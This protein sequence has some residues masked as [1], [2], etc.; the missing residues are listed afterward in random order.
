MEVERSEFGEQWEDIKKKD[1]VNLK[2]QP[3]NVDELLSLLR[4]ISNLGEGEW[5][6]IREDEELLGAK[7]SNRELALK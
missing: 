2:Q 6:L 3:W 4:G 5:N 7:R 1:L